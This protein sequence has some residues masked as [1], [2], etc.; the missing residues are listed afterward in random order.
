MK[1][2]G[3]IISNAYCGLICN[4]GLS[5]TIYPS[6]IVYR[7]IHIVFQIMRVLRIFYA[8]QILTKILLLLNLVISLIVRRLQRAQFSWP[9]FGL[10]LTLQ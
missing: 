3:N 8:A 1:I 5:N 9:I 7:L 2:R 4:R 10:S 6:F